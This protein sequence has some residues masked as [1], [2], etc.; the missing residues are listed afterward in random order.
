MKAIIIKADCTISRQNLQ[1]LEDMQSVV[2]GYIEAVNLDLF[3]TL[4][5]NENF[6]AEN[7]PTNILASYLHHSLAAMF[8]NVSRL[9]L[10]GDTFVVGPTD[11]E[12]DETDITEHTIGVISALAFAHDIEITGEW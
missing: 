12:G 2:G 9:M 1:S 8:G 4:F 10:C 11:D 3:G 6:I 5:C 7:M